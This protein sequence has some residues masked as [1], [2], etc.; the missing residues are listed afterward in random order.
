M[1]L[2]ALALVG[3]NTYLRYQGRS[4]T[5]QAPEALAQ[6]LRP[7]YRVQMPAGSGPFPTALLFSGCDGPK[8]NLARWT[9]ELNRLGWGAV[10]VDSHG[11]RGLEEAQKWRL[12]CAGQL[13]TGGERAG[14]IAVALA[15][16]RAMPGVDPDRIALVGA[17]HGGW[18]ILDLLALRGQGR[19]PYNLKSWPGAGDPLAGVVGAVLLYPYCGVGTQVSRHG[20]SDR[21]PLLFLLV[22]GDTIA[23][24][25]ACLAVAERA[26]EAGLPVEWHMIAGTTHGFDQQEKSMFSTLEFSPEATAEAMTAVDDF[27]GRIAGR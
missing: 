25:G 3:C 20:W 21:I 27:L 23:D 18:A 10:V 8:D 22:E 4:V 13:L 6:T 15:D 19:L 2:A 26:K 12:V 11:P 17:S 24:E 14:D 5:R 7:D 1:V 9:A 16:V